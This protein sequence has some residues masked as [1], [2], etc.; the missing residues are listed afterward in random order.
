RW[1]RR[2]RL[3]LALSAV[4]AVLFAGTA[5]AAEVASA[6]EVYILPRGEVIEDDL[7]VGAGEILIEGTVEGDLV[8]TGGYIEV[9][10]VVMGDVIAAGG[11]IVISGAV[12]DDARVAGG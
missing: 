12:Q 1:A 2:Y 8:A 3:A 5:L 9:S 11:G 7:Y 10:G 6:D 4:M